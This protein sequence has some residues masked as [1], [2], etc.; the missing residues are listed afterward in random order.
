MLGQSITLA[1]VISH[2]PFVLNVGVN[3]ISV[4]V[5]ETFLLLDLASK[6]AKV[7]INYML[8]DMSSYVA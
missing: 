3:D 2:T 4:V 7:E 5:R 6:V 1:R 8:R